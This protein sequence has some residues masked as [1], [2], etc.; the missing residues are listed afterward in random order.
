MLPI[1]REGGDGSAQRGQS[2]ISMI[3]LLVACAADSTVALVVCNWGL[4]SYTA[5]KSDNLQIFNKL[6]P[7]G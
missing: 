1:G 3:A 4:I 7:V 5:L 6:S 2:L